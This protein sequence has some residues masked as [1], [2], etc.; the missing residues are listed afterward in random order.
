M[1]GGLGATLIVFAV[2]HLVMVTVLARRPH[3]GLAAATARHRVR[4]ANMAR[5]KR[6][7]GPVVGRKE[8]S[9]FLAS[10]RR[11]VSRCHFAHSLRSSV[12]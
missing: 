3:A 5:I 10:P 2:M 4:Q 1:L 11:P 6:A 12:R 9:A 8:V 7:R